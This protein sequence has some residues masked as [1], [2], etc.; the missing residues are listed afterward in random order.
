MI[1]LEKAELELLSLDTTK[2]ILVNIIAKSLL[3]NN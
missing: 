2:P 3:G 1:N